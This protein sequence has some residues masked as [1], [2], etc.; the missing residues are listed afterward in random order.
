MDLVRELAITLSD[1]HFTALDEVPVTG[2]Y[3]ATIAP[4][5]DDYILEWQ[6]PKEVRERVL[7]LPALYELLQIDKPTVV[8]TVVLFAIFECIRRHYVGISI[9]FT[10]DID[11]ESGVYVIK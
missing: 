9:G 6:L 1:N 10:G 11:T 4:Y 8:D 7:S 5:K 2:L 3:I